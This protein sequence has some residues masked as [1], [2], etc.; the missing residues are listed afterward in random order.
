[1]VTEPFENK[2]KQK[3]SHKTKIRKMWHSRK[4]SF[5]KDYN[6]L[7]AMLQQIT[8]DYIFYISI[9]YKPPIF[10]YLLY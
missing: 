4:L 1:M 6:R 5:F 8:H 10:I 2:Q 7:R 3:G 9:Y